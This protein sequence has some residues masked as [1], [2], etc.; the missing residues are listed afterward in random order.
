ML[1][2]EQLPL[3]NLIGTIL[4]KEIHRYTANLARRPAQSPH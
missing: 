2:V 3:I 1:I 4:S